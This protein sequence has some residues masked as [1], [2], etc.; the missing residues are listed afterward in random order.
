LLVERA[1]AEI[2]LQLGD[3]DALDVKALGMLAA[4]GA[5]VALL[6]A[7]HD[8]LY[9]LWSLS[10]VF[11]G[12]A[13]VCHLVVIWPKKFEIGPDLAASYESLKATPGATFVYPQ[14]LTELL[15]SIALNN[16]KHLPRKILFLRLGFALFVAGV[17]TGIVFALVGA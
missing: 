3:S 12:L 7:S 9:R 4:E 17:V 16:E 2:E 6:V 1:W 10:A 13:A 14:L 15:G 11:F 8:D 5:A